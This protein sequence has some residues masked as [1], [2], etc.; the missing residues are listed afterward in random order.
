MDETECLICLEDLISKD[1]AVLSCNHKIHF[2]CLTEWINKK[3]N[4]SEICPICNSR[5]EII[6]IIDSKKNDYDIKLKSTKLKRYNSLNH[7][8]F[9]N[10]CNIL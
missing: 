4:L 6:N 7:N 2:G 1:I 10:C 3:N 8:L 5:G 9:L